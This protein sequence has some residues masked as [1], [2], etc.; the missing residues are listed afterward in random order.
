MSTVEEEIKVMKFAA[1]ALRHQTDAA[2]TDD[3]C[4]TYLAQGGTLAGGTKHVGTLL[5]TGKEEKTLE[6]ITGDDEI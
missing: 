1:S 6:D 4:S 2:S 5:D 3:G